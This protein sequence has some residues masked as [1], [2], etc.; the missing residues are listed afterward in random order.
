MSAQLGLTAA[1]LAL[2]WYHQASPAA[3]VQGALSV[4]DYDRHCMFVLGCRNL[5]C[6]ALI[7]V[8][9]VPTIGSG[10]TFFMGFN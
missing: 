6:L 10:T 3:A 7:Q 1:V 8:T 5:C 2:A 4:W 9:L